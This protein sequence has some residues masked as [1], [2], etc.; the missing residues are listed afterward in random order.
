MKEIFQEEES[1]IKTGKH[2]RQ[3]IAV[4]QLVSSS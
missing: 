2:L 1:E 3:D 4:S